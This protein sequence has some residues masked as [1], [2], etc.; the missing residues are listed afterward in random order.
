MI[1]Q[2]QRLN[3]LS[4]EYI[5]KSSSVT[6]NITN[7]DMRRDLEASLGNFAEYDI[8]YVE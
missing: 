1:W 4:R 3:N 2:P 7:V 8:C 5:S 6:S